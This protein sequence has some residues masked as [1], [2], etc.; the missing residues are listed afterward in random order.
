MKDLR[1]HST[2]TVAKIPLE[3]AGKIALRIDG[4][5]L[6]VGPFGHKSD[7]VA[8]ANIDVA[9]RGEGRLRFRQYGLYVL[10]GRGT[11]DGGAPP[12]ALIGR[13]GSESDGNTAR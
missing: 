10:A 11:A 5:I 7:P 8:G 13:I 3:G 9:R 2:C 1:T 6:W 12:F 4:V